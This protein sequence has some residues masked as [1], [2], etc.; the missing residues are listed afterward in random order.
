MLETAAREVSFLVLGDADLRRLIDVPSLIEPLEQA[1]VA[2]YE[3]KVQNPR[4]T[5]LF[6][7]EDQAFFGIMP[8]AVPASGALG[9]K[10]ITVFG[11]NKESGLPSHFGTVLLLDPETGSLRALMDA[12]YLTEAR[13]AAVSAI[14]VRHLAA[15]RPVRVGVL[16][17]GVQARGHAVAFSELFAPHEIRAW[18]PGAGL[19]GFVKDVQARDVPLTAAAD[20]EAAIRDADVVVLATDSAVPVLRDEWVAPGALVISVGACRPDHRE[21]DPPLLVRSRLFVDSREA[22]FVDSGDIVGGITEGRFGPEHV[23]GELGEVVAQRVS[24]RR[25]AS[26]ITVFKSLGLAVEDVVSAALAYARANGTGTGRV[27]TM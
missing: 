14:A 7:G 13:T 21:I 26:D 18:S 15:P 10:L 8:A 16:G 11:R 4:R 9:A 22:A 1:L 20:A 6:V 25:A 27:T 17:S 24:P 3:R 2:F 19:A 5:T 23:V 12:R